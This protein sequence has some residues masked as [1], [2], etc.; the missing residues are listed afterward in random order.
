MKYI[1]SNC[2]SDFLRWEGKCSNCGEWGTL[3]EGAEEPK[4]KALATSVSY[5]KSVGSAAT[6]SIKNIR[7]SGKSAGG[8]ERMST[9]FDEFDRVLGGGF[10]GG[11]AV[12]MSGSLASGNLHFY[13]RLQ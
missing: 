13:F 12:L 11:E 7:P 4:G 1:C 3:E 2:D 8:R 10:V 9:G 6:V 5:D